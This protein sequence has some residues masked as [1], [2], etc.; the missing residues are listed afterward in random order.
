MLVVAILLLVE[1]NSDYRKLLEK[2]V[3]TQLRLGDSFNDLVLIDFNNLTINLNTFPSIPKVLYV[4]STDCPYCSENL[5]FWNKAFRYYK[6][7]FDF[8][9]ISIDDID[10]TKKYTTSNKIDFEVYLPTDPNFRESYRISG[11][12]Q[13]II[14]DDSNAVI[15]YWLGLL[16]EE[17]TTEFENYLNLY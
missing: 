6:S 1:K 10:K 8:I 15:K 14:L 2:K 16:N 11:V 3:Y 7:Q 4:F 12:P 5:N 13:T 9:G 17:S